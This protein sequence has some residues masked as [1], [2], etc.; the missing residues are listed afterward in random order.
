[1]W[2]IAVILIILW[3]LVWCLLN[4]FTQPVIPAEAGIQKHRH[5]I[6]VFMGMTQDKSVKKCYGQDTRGP[7]MKLYIAGLARNSYMVIQMTGY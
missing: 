7:R 3:A 6:P 4:N 2:T 1:L 5:W